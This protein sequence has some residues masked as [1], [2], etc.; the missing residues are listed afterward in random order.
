M[1]F[2]LQGRVAVVPP[3]VVR[4]R[5]GRGRFSE[6]ERLA[7]S[8]CVPPA[9]R[10][11]RVPMGVASC[12]P[13]PWLLDPGSTLLTPGFSHQ[14]F[15]FLLLLFSDY[16]DAETPHGLFLGKRVEGMSHTPMSGRDGSA[17]GSASALWRDGRCT[18]P[19]TGAVAKGAQDG[20]RTPCDGGALVAGPSASGTRR[21]RAA[22]LTVWGVPERR[23]TL[24][25]RHVPRAEA[26]RQACLAA[27]LQA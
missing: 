11:A 10:R 20:G 2:C 4:R 1:G 9:R 12:A 7:H 3:L 22:Y 13:L 16:V 19:E 14:Y 6:W 23:T 5:W 15:P 18:C 17:R 21:F 24:M 25:D 8:G 27:A 26:V